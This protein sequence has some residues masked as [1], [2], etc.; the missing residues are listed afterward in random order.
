MYAIYIQSY[1]SGLQEE[2]EQL[3]EFKTHL[4]GLNRRA[5]T[6][7]QLKPRNTAYSVKG[8]LPI[9]AVCDFKQMEVNTLTLVLLCTLVIKEAELILGVQLR[10]HKQRFEPHFLF[11]F[12]YHSPSLKKMVYM[13]ITC[14]ISILNCN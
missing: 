6:I 2:K 10:T 14:V 4:E 5:K 1:L 8:K 13:E 9:Q 11:A 3:N 7:I 12:L